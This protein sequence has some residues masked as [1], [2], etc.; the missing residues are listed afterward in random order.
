MAEHFC[1]RI[2]NAETGAR[3]ALNGAEP[4]RHSRSEELG[5]RTVF[6]TAEM[7]HQGPG[8][9]VHGAG[10][11]AGPIARAGLDGVVVVFGEN[12]RGYA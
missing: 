1:S 5:A 8:I 11:R 7:F 10:D 12:L 6:E 2:A 4:S 9:D 3:Y